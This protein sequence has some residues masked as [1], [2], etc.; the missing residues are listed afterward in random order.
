MPVVPIYKKTTS[1]TEL[2]RHI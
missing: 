2:L 1:R